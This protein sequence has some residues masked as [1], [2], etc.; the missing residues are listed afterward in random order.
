MVSKPNGGESFIVGRIDTIKW[1]GSNVANV[2][3][4]YSIDNGANWTTIIALT[5]A[6]AGSYLWTIPNTPSTNCKVRISDVTNNLFADESDNVF[7]IILPKLTVL[8]PNGGESF[9]VGRT[10]TIKWSGSNVANV[11]LEYSIDNG[12][13][14][15][16]IIAST[17]ANAGSFLWTIP[18]N[19]SINCLV[20][21]SDVLFPDISDISDNDFAIIKPTITLLSP[22]GSDKWLIGTNRQISWTSTD[23]DSIRI[24]F[25]SDN[26]TTWNVIAPKVFAWDGVYLWNVEALPTTQALVRVSQFTDLSVQDVSDQT[27]TIYKE[28]LAVTAPNGGERLRAKT[29]VPV[30]WTISEIVNP[31]TLK[32]NLGEDLNIANA[33]IQNV[34]IDFT[35]DNGSTWN[36][37]VSS[38]SAAQKTYNWE[39]PVVESKECKIR[40]VDVEDASH[41]DT[42]NA[43]FEIY[44]PKLT[45][46]S[47]N[48]GEIWRAS[49]SHQITW[50]G[51]EISKIKIEYSANDGFTW[52]II[53][54]SVDAA[55]GSINWNIPAERTSKAKVRVTDVA[56]A[57]TADTSDKSFTILVPEI[58]LTAPAGGE[59]WK[60]NTIQQIKWNSL[61][62][63]Q[64]TIE[65]STNNGTNW[66]VVKDS[67]EAS[68]GVYNW[69]I[70]RTATD[71]AKVKISDIT[72][73][74]INA[75]SGQF[76]ILKPLTVVAPNGGEKWFSGSKQQVK[77]NYNFVDSVKLE[78]SLNNGATWQLIANSVPAALLAYDWNIPQNITSA[79]CR[80][81]ITDRS[82]TLTA[83][84][85]L[86]VFTIMNPTLT[87]LTP[88]GGENIKGGSSFDITW[89]NQNSDSLLIDYSID[90]GKTWTPV[91][92]S[93]GAKTEK[94]IWL[95][96]KVTSSLCFIRIIDKF[97]NTVGDTTDKVFSIYTPALSLTSPKGGESWYYGQSY[98]IKWQSSFV[99]KIKIDLTT[100]NGDTWATV[101]AQ[102]AASDSNFN[103]AA[104]KI[105]SILCKVRISSVEDPALLDTSKNYFSITVLPPSIKV[106]V[107]QNPVLTQYCNIVLVTDSLLSGLPVTKV[108]RNKDTAT[109]QMQP[110]PNS[111]FV[112]ETAIIFDTT[113]IY[114]INSRVVS[115]LGTEKDTTRQFAVGMILPNTAAAFSSPDR[116]LTLTVLPGVVQEKTFFSIEEE[117]VKNEK[118]YHLQ[119]EKTFDKPVSVKLSFAGETYEETFKLSVLTLTDGEWK[120]VPSDV[121]IKGETV[122]ASLTTF[123]K[124]KLGID[125]DKKEKIDLPQT[126]ALIQNYPNPFNPSTIIQYHLPQDCDVSLEIYNMLGAK[127]ATLQ[128]GFA[129]A[130]RYSVTWNGMNNNNVQVPSGVYLYR[131]KAG[132][133][134]Q[135]RK[136]IL[137]K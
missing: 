127:I 13:N 57:S 95:V 118:I 29:I 82:N 102:V 37:V 24:D 88:N 26:G 48:G 110:V 137:L 22:N 121:N 34:K 132:T 52:K 21:I 10:D 19:P 109:Y 11:K 72:L 73:K 87:V 78:Y 117:N 3:L 33:P 120:P 54:D 119:P 116:G 83:D 5:P 30:S 25:S 43:V 134:N 14:W 61:D 49:T 38:I 20:R 67:L 97:Y 35:S 100:N 28:A 44:N 122:T 94:L 45:V 31:K 32:K 8:K 89:K 133:F 111:A 98:D 71:Q 36:T 39:V 60:T 123:G 40:I 63:E 112:Y 77:W 104:G 46:T 136:M 90:S 47:P 115:K 70:P 114:T 86:E 41:A 135:V 107:F 84:S 58:S 1:S 93:F 55:T 129:S 92:K 4:E 108:W 124:I 80:V 53:S 56:L 85:S 126:F 51:S 66:L 79:Q 76:T 105:N 12:A 75:V 101:A 128:N 9:I 131:I 96:P 27:F 65:Y 103:L 6:N 64:I 23:L 99:E 17:P 125:A 16:A 74:E 62:V 81:K 18:N 2:K 68:S 42:S 130:G 69:T 7:S 50:T 91:S 15:T 113:A 106:T 59:N